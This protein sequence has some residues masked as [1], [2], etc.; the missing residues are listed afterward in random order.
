MSAVMDGERQHGAEETNAEMADELAGDLRL[1]RE[2]AALIAH[3]KKMYDRSSALAKIGIWECD[4]ATEALAWTDGVYDLFD[5][6]RGSPLDRATTLQ[7]YRDDSRR[8]ME[9]LRAE[10]VLTGGSFSM[11]IQIRTVMGNDR[12]LRLTADVEQ[13]NGRSVRIFGT[14]QDITQEKMAQEEVRALQTELIHISRVSAMGAMASTLAHELNQPLTAIASYVAGTRRAL[15]DPEQREEALKSGLEAIEKCVFRAS[16]ILRSLRTLPDAGVP[17]RY[18]L[19]PNPLVREAASLAMA[20]VGEGIV[21]RYDL[22]DGLAVFTDPVQIQQVVINLIRN[23]VEAVQESTRREIVVSTRSVDG[24]VEIGIEDSGCGIAPK[25]AETLFEAFVSSKP[26]RAGMGLSISR[27]IVE[28]HEGRISAAN[29]E[30]GGAS[31]C[32]TLPMPPDAA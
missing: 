29:R 22:A 10:A 14:K 19:D 21:L 4:L 15:Q 27:T 30:G 12:W 24:A 13:E 25:V 26:D 28:A 18:R 5:L 11:D 1:M 2:Q 3:Y 17:T 7:C 16:D 9:R 20:G 8:E 6:P 32:V 31:F 23:A